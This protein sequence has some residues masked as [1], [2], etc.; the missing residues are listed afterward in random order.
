MENGPPPRMGHGHISWFQDS[1]LSGYKTA[2]LHFF[3]KSGMNG[4]A[5]APHG[6]IQVLSEDGAI[7]SRM[8]II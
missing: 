4:F 2:K 7:P 6:L 3:I 1:T 8:L 5:M